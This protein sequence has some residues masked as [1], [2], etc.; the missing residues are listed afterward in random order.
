MFNYFENKALKVILQD[1]E[2]DAYI[3]KQISN[4]EKYQN[5]VPKIKWK[6]FK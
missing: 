4:V 1:N 2:K 5:M 6:K 3:G